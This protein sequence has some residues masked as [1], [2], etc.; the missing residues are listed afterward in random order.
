[1]GSSLKRCSTDEPEHAQ[2]GKHTDLGSNPS[3]QG[4]CAPTDCVRQAG[5]KESPNSE[6]AGGDT[7]GEIPILNTSAMRKRSSTSEGKTQMGFP[8]IYLPVDFKVER[9]HTSTWRAGAIH[10]RQV[11]DHALV[12]LA[13]S[14]LINP[15]GIPS[16]VVD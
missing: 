5:R 12:S 6:R 7:L 11:T 9:H 13:I 4:R 8:L 2:A 14:L 10:L 1:M 16:S 3:C 15:D